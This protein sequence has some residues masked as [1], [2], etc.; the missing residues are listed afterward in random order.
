[1]SPWVSVPHT[2]EQA[3]VLPWPPTGIFRVSS[4]V[5]SRFPIQLIQAG[6]GVAGWQR[7]PGVQ[8]DLV[9]RAGRLPGEE[10]AGRTRT[11][12]VCPAWPVFREMRVFPRRLREVALASLRELDIHK[13]NTTLSSG[14]CRKPPRHIPRSVYLLRDPDASC[15]HS[16]AACTPGPPSPGRRLQ[17][18]GPRRQGGHA[19]TLACRAG[20]V[21]G[22]QAQWSV[23]EWQ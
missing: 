14:V 16:K 5:C 15:C 7:P 19:G 8:A 6:G 22:R 20:G 18:R 4:H 13:E 9:A 2:W 10:A 17:L 11:R 21:V 12:G 1:M 3:S 23:R